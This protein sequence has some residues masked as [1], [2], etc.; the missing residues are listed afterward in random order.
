MTLALIFQILR[1]SC[2]Y[3]VSLPSLLWRSFQERCCHPSKPEIT[4]LLLPL[5]QMSHTL[6]FWDND[7]SP[8]SATPISL[9][10][11]LGIWKE[12]VLPFLHQDITNTSPSHQSPYST[13]KTTVI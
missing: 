9:H 3:R 2:P 1:I 6:M 12:E 5:L 11:C 4:G 8:A 13:A 10:H 7:L